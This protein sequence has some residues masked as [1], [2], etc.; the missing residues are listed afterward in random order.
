KIA[1]IVV[2]VGSRFGLHAVADRAPR[3][4]AAPSCKSSRRATRN[5]IRDNLIIRRGR[6]T[7]TLDLLPAADGSADAV[8]PAALGL[9]QLHVGI[10]HHVVAAARFGHSCR[11]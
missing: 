2:I 1:G 9:V 7:G 5:D 4:P 6:S 8:A 3:A 11:D 10:V